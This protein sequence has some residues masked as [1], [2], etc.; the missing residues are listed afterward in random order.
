MLV[1]MNERSQTQKNKNSIVSLYKFI[2]LFILKEVRV[3]IIFWGRE[4]VLTRKVHFGVWQMDNFLLSKIWCQY[5]K[6]KE[7]FYAILW[8][9]RW[10]TWMNEKKS[11]MKKEYILN[12]HLSFKGVYH[13]WNIYMDIYLF[14]KNYKL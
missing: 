9:D 3:I 5:K 1:T 8:S 6:N 13:I 10:D 12:Y 7:W 2:Y 14:L 4:W 11:K